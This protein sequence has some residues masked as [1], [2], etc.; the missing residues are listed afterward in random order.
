[1]SESARNILRTRAYSHYREVAY[2]ILF[3][4]KDR[5]LHKNEILE[6][7]LAKNLLPNENTKR[8]AT[9]ISAKINMEIRFKNQYFHK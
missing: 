9:Q 8:S 6:E 2:S 5:C 4:A 1:M 3:G 7:A